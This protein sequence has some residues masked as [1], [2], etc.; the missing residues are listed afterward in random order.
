MQ[1]RTA[2]PSSA[3]E[4]DFA[5][6]A[7]TQATALREGRFADLDVTN[8]TEEIDDPSN[9]KRDIVRS[10]L[11]QNFTVVMFGQITIDTEAGPVTSDT[12]TKPTCARA[13]SGSGKTS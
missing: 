12:A 6:W 11:K 2:A 7:E 13:R 4:S 10:R 9:R 3:Y 8:L 5:Q 1:Q